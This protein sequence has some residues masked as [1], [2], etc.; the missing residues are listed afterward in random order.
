M[1]ARGGMCEPRV[2]CGGPTVCQTLA[3]ILFRLPSRPQ[4]GRKEPQEQVG[5]LRCGEEGCAQGQTQALPCAP[6]SFARQASP[7]PGPPSDYVGLGVSG[8]GSPPTA[9]PPP[10]TPGRLSSLGGVWLGGGGGPSNF[11]LPLLPGH[12]PF[13]AAGARACPGVTPRGGCGQE[14]GAHSAAAATSGQPT[15][16]PGWEAGRRLAKAGTRGGQSKRQAL[17]ERQ[18]KR[19]REP[20]P[21]LLAAPP[22]WFSW[23]GRL[24][25]TQPPARRQPPKVLLDPAEPGVH[26]LAPKSCN[27]KGR[28]PGHS[29]EVPDTPQM[30]PS[31]GTVVGPQIFQ[32]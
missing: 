19:D 31:Q 27:P 21:G 9:S 4:G 1:P 24:R 29:G 6:V 20:T 30:A 22:P 28:I 11:L 14:Q 16:W 25:L 10:P 7:A 15:G 23:I 18:R 17:G 8:C 13:K 5:K 26:S 12:W 3:R 32:T 2:L